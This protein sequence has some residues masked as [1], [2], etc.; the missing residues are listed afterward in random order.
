MSGSSRQVGKPFPTDSRQALVLKLPRFSTKVKISHKVATVGS[1]IG[2]TIRLDKK[3]PDDLLP[4]VTSHEMYEHLLQ[5]PPYKLSYPEAHRI[6]L[7]MDKDRFFPNDQK[8]FERYRKVI[9][10]I[11]EENQKVM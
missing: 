4:I 7:K 2:D 11:F 6:A 8:G 3:I 10:R 5:K 1:H 9:Y